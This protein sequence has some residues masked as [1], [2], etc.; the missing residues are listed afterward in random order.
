MS[1]IDLYSAESWSISTSLCVLSGSD[2]SINFWWWSSPG[3][4]FR[5]IFPLPSALQNTTFQDI[6]FL[7]A[8][9][10]QSPVTFR[11]MGA[12]KMREWKMQEWKMQER[13]S[14]ESHQQKYSKAPDE[15]W[16]SWLSCLVLAKR[17]SQARR[18]VDVS[19]EKKSPLLLFVLSSVSGCWFHFAQALLISVCVNWAWWTH[20]GTTLACRT[21]SGV[22]CLFR[23]CRSTR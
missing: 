17:N 9:L 4:G 10:I 20:S 23:S 11:E 2:E 5:G 3:D 12:L 22:F 14:M 16:L 21:C 6:N 1:I 7:L 15:I 18:P 8:F 13:Q 19:T